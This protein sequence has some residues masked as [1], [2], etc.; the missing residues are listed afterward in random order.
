MGKARLFGIAAVVSAAAAL[1]VA[2]VATGA[3]DTRQVQV[4]D[5][6]DSTTFD[7]VL[8]DGA[9]V[10]A[11]GVTFEAFIA[12]LIAQGRAPAWRFAPERLKLGAGGTID[13]VNRGGEF[14]TF[15]EVA[16]FGGGCIDELNE[17][18]GLEPVPECDTPGI[19]ASTGLPAGES[20]TTAP[21]RPGT[22]RFM[23]LIHPWMRTTATVG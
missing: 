5:A 22:H 12:Q 13:A 1:V 9:C 15:T 21:V 19:F 2:A 11:G 16:E 20:L 8:G 7:A 3:A 4:L 18:L 14:H 10:R 17:L 6:C 23:C